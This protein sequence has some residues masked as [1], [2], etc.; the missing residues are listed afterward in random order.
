MFDSIPG[1][2]MVSIVPPAEGVP[3]PRDVQRYAAILQRRATPYLVDDRARALQSSYPES[4]TA[5]T[6]STGLVTTVLDLAKFDLA[7]KQGILLQSG[8]LEHAWSTPSVN[9]M[10]VAA[11]HRVVRADLQR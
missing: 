9:G 6:P 11:R 8:T 3:D 2:N 4:T 10:T 1:P 5:L 7:L